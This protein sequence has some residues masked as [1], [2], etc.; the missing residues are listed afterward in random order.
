MSLSDWRLKLQ[1][2]VPFSSA[3]MK[4][5]VINSEFEFSALEGDVN[6]LVSQLCAQNY[7]RPGA[8]SLRAVT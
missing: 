6:R 8:L 2:S 5:S 7:E 4:G 3:G 1:R